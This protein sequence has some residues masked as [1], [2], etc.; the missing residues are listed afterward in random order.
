LSKKR[1]TNGFD[2]LHRISDLM[3][4]LVQVNGKMV[5]ERKKLRMSKE[6][7]ALYRQT[8]MDWRKRSDLVV[9][10]GFSITEAY[11]SPDVR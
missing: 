8:Y 1:R 5:A 9:D 10:A 3:T 11:D 4:K 6:Q 2:N 7:Y